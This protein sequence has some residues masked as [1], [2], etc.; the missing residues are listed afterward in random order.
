MIQTPVSVIAGPYLCG[1]TTLT[2]Q[3]IRANPALK[4]A[5]L[6]NRSDQSM[7]DVET[8]SDA[9]GRCLPVLGGCICCTLEDSFVG[10]MLQITAVRDIYDHILIEACGE[11]DP[12][13][14]MEFAEADPELL[15][16]RILLPHPPGQAPSAITKDQTPVP[17]GADF[18]LALA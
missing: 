17:W 18:D 11:A 10:A 7:A 12:S 6:V 4:C 1:K 16:A 3:L 5:V 9:G 13:K 14:V 2:A 15:P 8:L